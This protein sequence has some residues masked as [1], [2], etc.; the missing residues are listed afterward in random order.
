M[1]KSKLT[2]K[3]FVIIVALLLCSCKCTKNK[4]TKGN[5]KSQSDKGTNVFQNEHVASNH[6]RGNL[7]I[8][9]APE[10][11]KITENIEEIVQKSPTRKGHILF[12]L[13]LGTKSHIFFMKSLVEGLL[14]NGHEVTTIFY[15]KTN[16]VH[17]NY[18]EVLIKD[19]YNTS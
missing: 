14:Q 16:I 11:S 13:Q 6:K 10:N 9:S 12:F 19:R 5:E 18:T 8:N 17:E 2:S 15:V 1:L 4:I 7:V 3:L